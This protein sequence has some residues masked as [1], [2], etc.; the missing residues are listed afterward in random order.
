MISKNLTIFASLLV[1]EEARDVIS[2]GKCNC[3]FK[4]NIGVVTLR[5]KE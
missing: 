4:V 5:F 2:I 3:I 1:F